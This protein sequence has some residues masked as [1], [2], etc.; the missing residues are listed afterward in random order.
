MSS[1]M[2][3]KVRLR[4]A[5]TGEKYTTALRYVQAHPEE[6]ERLRQLLQAQ[7]DEKRAAQAEAGQE[8]N[9]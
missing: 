2:S 6:S 1:D 7:R 9:A 5:Q 3:R 4:M 8:G